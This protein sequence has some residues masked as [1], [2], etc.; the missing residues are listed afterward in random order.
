M[1][2]QGVEWAYD[3]QRVKMHQLAA[4]RGVAH[5]APASVCGALLTVLAALPCI[6]PAPYLNCLLTPFLPLTSLHP[7]LLPVP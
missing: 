6:S 7:P 2:L 4:K 5:R 3:Q 1:K